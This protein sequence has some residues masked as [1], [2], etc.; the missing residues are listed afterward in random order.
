MVTQLRMYRIKRGKM[1]EW[2]REWREGVYPLRMRFGYAIEG[3]WVAQGQN[4]FVWMLSYD[5]PRPWEEKEA[6]Y[7]DSPERRNLKP[8]PARYIEDQQAWFLTPALP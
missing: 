1:Q 8:D 2:I 6:E 5:G 7:Y 4:T 3:A